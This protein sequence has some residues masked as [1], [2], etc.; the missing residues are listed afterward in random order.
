MEITPKEYRGL[1]GASNIVLM[2]LGI[3]F[4]YCLGFGLPKNAL[5]SSEY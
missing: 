3:F 2:R 1:T 4:N 5:I